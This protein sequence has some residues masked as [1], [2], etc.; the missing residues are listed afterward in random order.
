MPMR[1]GQLSFFFSRLRPGR[2][3]PQLPQ[4]AWGS[5]GELH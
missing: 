4:A 2:T 1:I 5:F 3:N